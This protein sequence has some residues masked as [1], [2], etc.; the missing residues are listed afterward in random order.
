MPSA[1]PELQAEWPGGDLEAI[2]YLEAQGYRQTRAFGWRRPAP[3]HEPTE[4][5]NSALDY[6]WL[7][8]DWGGIED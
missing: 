6:L 3:D 8:W 4:R 7:E 1:P 5:E 2:Q